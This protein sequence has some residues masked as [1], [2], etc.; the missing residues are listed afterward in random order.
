MALRIGVGILIA[1]LVLFVAFRIAANYGID[2]K[3]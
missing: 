2:I 3:L 1:A